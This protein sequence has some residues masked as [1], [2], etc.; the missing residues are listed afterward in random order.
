[1][2]IA[3]GEIVLVVVDEDGDFDAGQVLGDQEW[4]RVAEA[5]RRSVASAVDPSIF[6]DPRFNADA[7]R[8]IE[9]YLA[10]RSA[11]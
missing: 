2:L 9:A 3:P 8:Q 6:A 1:M 7:R 10:A 4:G 5:L 11:E